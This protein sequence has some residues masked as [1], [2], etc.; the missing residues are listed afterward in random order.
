MN[1]IHKEEELSMSKKVE[2]KSALSFYLERFAALKE[3][4]GYNTR[5]IKYKL[6][7]I[8]RFYVENNI[9]TPI[10][11]KEII[12]KWR[13]SRINDRIGT[14]HGKYSTWAQLAR[15][16]SRNGCECYIPQLPR[17]TR[18]MRDG[19]APYIFTH[20]QMEN[21]FACSDNLHLR[22]NDVRNTLFCV[23][24]IL[25]L[26]YSTGVRISEA[27]SI[28]N[29][30]ININDRYIHICKSKNGC[31]RLVPINDEL[32]SVMAQYQLYRDRIPL[33]NINSPN[34]LFFIKPDRTA[35]QQ[36]AIYKWF[37]KILR[38]CGIPY[39]G[40]C[41]GPRLHDLRHTMAVHAL[42]QMV[43]NDMDL[44]VA[45]PIISACLGH[46][47][48]SATG[49]YVRLAHEMFPELAEQCS[50]LTSFVYPNI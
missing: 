2:Y 6:L 30:D 25:R 29:E 24:S 49:Q 42:E 44:Y 5:A 9:E 22:N 16:M 26:L 27:L 45:M 43:R 15:F 7:E 41:Q 12:D 23:P 14:L 39:T 36:Q 1:F 20:E 40:N 47:S 17:Y 19:Y 13:S 37:R 32:R 33:K 11:T 4:V 50:Q 38:R 48:L 34:S 3:A 21:I 10:I 8:D 35:C 18:S 31:E 46:K 28:R